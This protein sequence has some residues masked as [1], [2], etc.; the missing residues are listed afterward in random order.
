[1]NT[2]SIYEIAYR[3]VLTWLEAVEINEARERQAR[4]APVRWVGS[5]LVLSDKLGSNGVEETSRLYGKLIFKRGLSSVNEWNRVLTRYLV[6]LIDQA[7]DGVPEIAKTQEYWPAIEK[8]ADDCKRAITAYDR[9]AAESSAN[10]ARSSATATIFAYVGAEVASDADA[11]IAAARAAGVAGVAAG[12]CDDFACVVDAARAD[13][14]DY[15]SARDA[16]KILFTALLD[17]IK[18]EISKACA[19]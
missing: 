5:T 2:V 9:D 1:M 7:L 13:D 19:F 3:N 6:R 18:L 4:F 17:E 12:A 14:A 11:A 8:A 16:A 10:S 15:E